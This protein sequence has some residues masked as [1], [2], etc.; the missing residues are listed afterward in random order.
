LH[1]LGTHCWTLSPSLCGLSA[2]HYLFMLQTSTSIYKHKHSGPWGGRT[3]NL[4]I[5]R[6]PALTAGT[7][8]LHAH[9]QARTTGSIRWLPATHAEAGGGKDPMDGSNK[10]GRVRT[11]PRCRTTLLLPVTSYQRRLPAARAGRHAACSDGFQAAAFPPP[12][13]TPCLLAISA[14]AQALSTQ[15]ATATPTNTGTTTLRPLQKANCTA[16]LRHVLADGK[17]VHW[18]QGH[19]GGRLFGHSLT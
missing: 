18:R 5:G 11:T 12:S 8:C 14:A 2:Q 7:A 19:S 10:N 9:L 16:A 17:A 15:D 6:P 4:S 1:L 13:R 3:G